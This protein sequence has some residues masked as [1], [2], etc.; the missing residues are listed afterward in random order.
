[1]AGTTR[2]VGPRSRKS[3]IAPA[4][5]AAG[6]AIQRARAAGSAVLLVVA[7]PTGAGR[8]LGRIRAEDA[9][10]RVAWSVRDGEV[11]LAGVGLSLSVEA[12]GPEA[13]RQAIDRVQGWFSRTVSWG[14]GPGALPRFLGGAAFDPAN[15]VPSWPGFPDAWFILPRVLFWRHG[16]EHGVSVQLVVDP[17]SSART[18]ADELAAG[19][20]LAGRT[21]Q[22]EVDALP[23]G[24]RL[25]DPEDRARWSAGAAEALAEIA[26][27]RLKKVVLARSIRVHADGEIDAAAVFGTLSRSTGRR[28]CFLVENGEAGFVGAS[29]ERLLRVAGDEVTAD[30]IAGTSPRDGDPAVDR[31]IAQDLAASEKDLREHA[32]VVE[33]VGSVFQRHCANVEVAAQPEVL[34]LASVHHLSTPIRGRLR[35]GADLGALVAELHPTPAVGG[36]PRGEALAFIRRVEAEN[37]GWYAGPIGVIEPGRAEFVVAIRSALIQGCTAQVFAGS[38]IV[39]GSAPEVEWRET[40]AKAA[41]LL[42][43]LTRGE[44]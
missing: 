24:H 43:V 36:L 18:V 25:E 16:A 35:A 32:L 31:A 44:S 7:A 4:L 13:L 15:S 10:P 33:W 42:A 41:Q 19:L 2:R 21:S 17:D 27:G 5:E 23:A 8:P 20:E 30:C 40:E 38:G 14:S 12:S 28:F 22:V 39:E 9:R 3:S 1:M 34:T 11:E 29:P 37:R 6:E 26:S